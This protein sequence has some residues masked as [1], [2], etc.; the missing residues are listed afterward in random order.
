MENFRVGVVGC[1]GIA[2]VHLPCSAPG[3]CGAGWATLISNRAGPGLRRNLRRQG[4]QLW[5]SCWRVNSWTV[6]LY[7][8][9]PPHPHGERRPAAGLHVFHG[10]A[11][12]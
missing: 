1:G 11:P 6:H 3:G 10:K 9:L 4:V 8:P 2:Q 7:T 5:R 12:R